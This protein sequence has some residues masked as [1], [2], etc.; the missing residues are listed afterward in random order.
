MH[1]KN[2]SNEYVALL[3]EGLYDRIPKTVLAAIA[4]SLA[5]ITA[6]GAMDDWSG[7]RKRFMDEWQALYDNGIV[8]QKPVKLD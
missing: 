5:N 2:K 1:L 8:S 3:G 4:F 6:D 7:A